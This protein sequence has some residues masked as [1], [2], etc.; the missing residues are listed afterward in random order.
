[1]S[2]DP[3]TGEHFA[4]DHGSTKVVVRSDLALHAN[5]RC[6]ATTRHCGRPRRRNVLSFGKKSSTPSQAGW[7]DR[8][9]SPKPIADLS[10][11]FPDHRLGEDDANELC[12]WLISNDLAHTDSSKS[13]TRMQQAS[14][15]AVMDRI[16]SSSNPIAFRIPLLQ[17]ND[18]ADRLHRT[19]GWLVRSSGDRNGDRGDAACVLPGDHE[20]A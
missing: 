14:R 20:L 2:G 7:T 13:S 15:R 5:R 12:R 6:T 11:S 10:V 1:M 19:I 16:R 9:P 4:S 18:L 8:V 3:K 17:P